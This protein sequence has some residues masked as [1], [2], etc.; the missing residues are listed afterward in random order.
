MR[1]LVVHPGASWSVADVEAGLSYGLKTH[2]VEVIPYRLDV[3]I[4]RAQGWLYANWRKAK[5]GKPELPKPTPADVAYQASVEIVEKALRFQ[6]TAVLIVSA[7][8]L[9][10]D[11]LVLLRR[12]R[13][14]VFVLFTESPY[15]TEKELAVAKIVDGLWTNERSSL[16]A[17]RAVNPRSGYLPHAWH[18]ERHLSG[19]QPGDEAV[20]AHDVV[21]VGTAFAE[22][23]EWFAAIDWRGLDLGLY[24]NWQALPS[25]HPLR[26]FVRGGVVDNAT[27]AA[28]Y[29]RSKIGLNLYRSSIGWGAQAPR[30]A[31][32]DSLNPRAYELAACGVF[33]LSDFRPEVEELFGDWVPTFSRPVEA[34]ALIRAWLADDAGRASVAAHLPACVAASSWA[35]RAATVIGDIQSLLAERAA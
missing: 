24:G 10:P 35:E 8:F 21:F 14:S 1:L 18:P 17:F 5:R 9:H 2:G 12:A 27:A 19:P 29:R 16:P 13:I 22:R 25:R 20:A 7:M 32:A 30:I 26:R 28:L 11:V 3:R 15:D 31:A 33:H 4:E 34:A 6:V 23:I